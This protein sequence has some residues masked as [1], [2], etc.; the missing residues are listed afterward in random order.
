[1]IR[2]DLDDLKRQIP[3]L[4]YLYAQDWR[5]ARQLSRSRWMGLCPIGVNLRTFL[6]KNVLWVGGFNN[7]IPNML[8]EQRLKL[9]LIGDR[10]TAYCQ[11]LCR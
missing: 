4:D 9:T 6:V 3:L 10:P 5:P 1:M 8:W 2:Q 7:A 11:G